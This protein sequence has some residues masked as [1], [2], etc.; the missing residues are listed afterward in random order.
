[1][2][3][4]LKMYK[5]LEVEPFVKNMKYYMEIDVVYMTVHKTNLMV[6]RHVIDINKSGKNINLIIVTQ[7]WQE[8]KEC[9]K[10]LKRKIPG[11]L[12]FVEF[13]GPMIMMMM[14]MML[15]FHAKISLVL[16]NSM[17]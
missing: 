9:Y 17:A 2:I 16:A 12:A 3:D 11:N 13:F 4:A 8:S 1:M 15:K 14:M 6:H 7:V 5:T 10:D